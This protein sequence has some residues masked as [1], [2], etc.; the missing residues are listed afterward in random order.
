[1]NRLAPLL[2]AT[3]VTLAAFALAL[4]SGRAAEPL[5]PPAPTPARDLRPSK[6][7][8]GTPINWKHPLAEGLVSAVPLNEGAGNAFYDAATKETYTAKALAGTSKDAQPPAWITP[9]VTADYPWGGPAI[10]NNH[11][12][13]QSICAHV[14]EGHQFIE[15]VKTGYS[16]AVLVQPLDDKTFGRIMDCTGAAVL[17]MYLNIP[18][19]REGQVSTT[20]RNVNGT[21]INPGVK[22]KLNEWI[23]VLFTVQDGLGVMY[24]NGQ[25]VARDAHVDLAKSCAGQTGQLVYNATG[26]GG[27]MTHA[28]FASWWV[29]NN[30]ALTAAEAAQFAANPWAMFAPAA[31]TPPAPT[32]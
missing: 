14:K 18:K 6:P 9:P 10:S 24:I 3:T 8:P 31:P 7:P 17:T 25:E 4:P 32:R 16:Y 1:M 26:N 13:A 22:F 5:T 21:A 12:T 23:L 2:M 15:K 19:G 28:N 29:W 27:M 20:W 30:R 11:A